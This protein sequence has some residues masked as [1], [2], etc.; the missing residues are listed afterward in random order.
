MDLTHC[1][2]V[3]ITVIGFELTYLAVA[4]VIC[5]HWGSYRGGK[6]YVA[7]FEYM[8]PS[9]NP[10]CHRFV[11]PSIYVIVFGYV[12]P[13][14]TIFKHMLP[15]SNICHHLQTCV[16]VF[17]IWIPVDPCHLHQVF[18]ALVESIDVTG[19]DFGTSE[20][21]LG[22]EVVSLMEGMKKRKNEPQFSLWFIVGMHLMGLLF[23]GSPLMFLPLPFLHQLRMSWPTSLWKG[24][25]QVCMHPRW[26]ELRVCDL[27]P[28]PSREG[29]G[30]LLG[31]WVWLNV[32]W[33]GDNKDGW[34]WNGGKWT[35]INCDVVDVKL[36]LC[37]AI[38]IVFDIGTH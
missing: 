28:Y 38:K 14:V 13:S 9:S 12:S 6:P 27:G 17:G 31:C 10:C 32:E 33:S 35:N 20:K 19:M 18:V 11:L 25:G 21:L 8:S 37:Y 34:W 23:L 3:Q 15:S 5:W 26:G 16:T 7:L 36:K 1:C 29:M 30:T 2:G 4:G 22:R 24:E